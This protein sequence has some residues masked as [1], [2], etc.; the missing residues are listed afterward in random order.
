MLSTIEFVWGWRGVV[1]FHFCWSPD[2]NLVHSRSNELLS[3]YVK[4]QKMGRRCYD[5]FHSDLIVYGYDVSPRTHVQFWDCDSKMK[6]GKSRW[7]YEVGRMRWDCS[8]QRPM[9]LI[10]GE[11][12]KLWIC[13]HG[14][15]VAV[16]EMNMANKKQEHD[17]IGLYIFIEIVARFRVI[18]VNMALDSL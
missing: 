8:E 7:K 11:N 5:N 2:T 14:I 17:S 12:N 13:F 3:P 1:F 15:A 10:N 6:I 9:G 4:V 18:L 16:M